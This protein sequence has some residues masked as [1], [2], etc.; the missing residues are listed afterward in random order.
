MEPIA[1]TQ[2]ENINNCDRVNVRNGALVD[3]DETVF[4]C[5]ISAS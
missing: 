1:T 4:C 2:A 5:G 3:S